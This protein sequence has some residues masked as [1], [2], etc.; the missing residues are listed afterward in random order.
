VV[1]YSFPHFACLRP[2]GFAQDMLSESYSEIGL[3]FCR[4]GIFE[5]K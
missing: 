3:R 2:F 5:V 1:S 4:A